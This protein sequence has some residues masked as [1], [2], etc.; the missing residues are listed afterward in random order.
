MG[1]GRAMVA[2]GG[3]SLGIVALSGEMRRYNTYDVPSG[4]PERLRYPSVAKVGRCE[5]VL[6]RCAALW[7]AAEVAAVPLEMG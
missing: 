3:R 6:G 2:G 7:A 4:I 1:V 5:A